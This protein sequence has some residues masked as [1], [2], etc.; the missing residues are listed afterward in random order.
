MAEIGN[1][2]ERKRIG[3]NLE[4]KGV[5]T[6]TQLINGVIQLK[7]TLVNGVTVYPETGEWVSEVINIG[8]NF[9]DYDNLLTNIV[10]DGDST[11]EVFTRSSQNGV[12]FTDLVQ[13]DSTNKILSQKNQYTQVRVRVYPAEANN[14]VQFN[15]LGYN[16]EQVEFTENSVK[17]KKELEFEMELDETWTPEGFL[18]RK[19]VNRLED[20]NRIDRLNVSDQEL[21]VPQVASISFTSAPN[22]EVIVVN[23]NTVNTKTLN[24]RVFQNSEDGELRGATVTTTG[25][26]VGL[27]INYSGTVNS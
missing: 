3:I 20:W 17:L 25:E 2:I 27:S 24:E 10:N 26:F 5:Y 15:L 19:K 18:Y 12:N 8:D 11:V 23:D 13:V 4:L 7:P 6:N 21:K 16:S 14:N 9:R 22:Q 1:V